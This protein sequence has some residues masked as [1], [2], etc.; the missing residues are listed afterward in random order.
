MAAFSAVSIHVIVTPDAKVY[1]IAFLLA[2]VSGFLFGIVPVRQV[3]RANPWEIV[4]AGSTGVSGRR[5]TL[6][7]ALA[8]SANRHLCCVGHL[9]P[10]RGSW[11][12]ALPAQQLRL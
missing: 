6:R 8:G 10:R 11:T 3:L 1:A 7:D 2:T 9:F 12:R 4:K 5:I